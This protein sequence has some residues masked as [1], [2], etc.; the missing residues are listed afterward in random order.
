MSYSA[1]QR[2]IFKTVIHTCWINAMSNISHVKLVLYASSVI[3]MLKY[4]LCK[5][6]KDM[7]FKFAFLMSWWTKLF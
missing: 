6:L 5:Y 4:N 3:K 7:I 2:P 1:I